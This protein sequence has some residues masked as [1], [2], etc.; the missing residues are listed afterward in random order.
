MEA[1]SPITPKPSVEEEIKDIKDYLINYLNKNYLVK[2]GKINKSEKIVFIIEETDC[3]KN[4]LYK[5]EFSLDYLKQLS[6]LFRIFDSIDEAYNDI[7][8]IKIIKMEFTSIDINLILTSL[9]SKNEDICIKVK[10]NYLNNEKINE[11]LFKE[12][13]EIKTVL[14]EEKLKN[15]NLQ[16][17]IDEIVKEN[18]ELKNQIKE[19]L[20]WKNSQLIKKENN[21]ENNKDDNNVKEQIDSKIIKTKEE[22]E[23]L[24]KRLT[25]KGFINNRKIIFHLLYRAS[26]DGDSPYDYHNKCDGK[27]NTLCVIQTIKG[28]KFGGYTETTIKSGNG[29]DDKDPNAFVFSLNK[30]KIYENL[31]KGENAVCHSKDWGPI[32]RFDAFAVWNRNFFSYDM[33][34]VGSKLDSHY[35]IMNQDYEINN[36]EANFGIKELEVYQIIIE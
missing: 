11:I 19:L 13:N 34:T 27:S 24:S 26:R 20:D 33:H 28:C 1:P 12:L 3:I 30:Y 25:S 17:T 32:F 22:I 8:D 21:S 18:K 14:K 10:K 29:E 2:L 5:S 16:K 36:G 35:G 4:Y 6:K 31:K 23:L 9:I 7:S 15:E